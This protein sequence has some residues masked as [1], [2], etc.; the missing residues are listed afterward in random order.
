MFSNSRKIEKMNGIIEFKHNAIFTQSKTS[1]FQNFY[2]IPPG[3]SQTSLL[4]IKDVFPNYN[5]HGKQHLFINGAF[6]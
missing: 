5:K 4:I 2:K 3:S 1:H 6:I